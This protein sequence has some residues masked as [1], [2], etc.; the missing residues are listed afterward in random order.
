MTSRVKA[1]L[2]NKDILFFIDKGCNFVAWA[3]FIGIEMLHI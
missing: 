3:I 1:F 2:H